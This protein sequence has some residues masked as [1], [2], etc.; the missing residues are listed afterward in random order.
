M[1]VQSS[2]VVIVSILNQEILWFFSG[3]FLKFRLQLY[4]SL[5]FIPEFWF[6]IVFSEIHK[7]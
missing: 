2:A 7:F 3:N 1:H 5:G 4:Q 6:L